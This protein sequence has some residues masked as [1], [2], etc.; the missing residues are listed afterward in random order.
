M[1]STVSTARR[2]EHHRDR[3]ASERRQHLGVAGKVVAAREQGRFVYRSSD[4]AV[5][6]PG[7]SQLDSALDG[8]ARD[9]ASVCRTTARSPLPDSDVHGD[10]CSH[11][12]NERQLG[13]SST[14]RVGAD[15]A[16]D[17]RSDPAR[18]A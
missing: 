5:D 15:G 12:T 4:D 7:K 10:A 17:L 16:D 18:V 8:A 6:L 13:Q 9:L 2:C 14:R 1:P 3:A 11:R